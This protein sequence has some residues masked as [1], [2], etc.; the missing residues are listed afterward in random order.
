MIRSGAHKDFVA[1]EIANR[2][3]IAFDTSCLVC[4][5]NIRLPLLVGSE[6]VEHPLLKINYPRSP[7][8]IEVI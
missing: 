2:N 7:L 6:L 1:E 3:Q 4:Y 8:W 5:P